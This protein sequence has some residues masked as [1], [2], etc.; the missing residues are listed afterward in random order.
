[1]VHSGFRTFNARS[2]QVLSIILYKT[3]IIVELEQ[4]PW[5]CDRGIIV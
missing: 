3:Y 1:M 2:A 4:Q 5:N